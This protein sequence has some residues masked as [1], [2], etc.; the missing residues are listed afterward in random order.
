MTPQIQSLIA[1]ER[2]PENYSDM[3]TQ[4]WRPLAHQIAQW[5]KDVGR[6][7]VIG[8]N[9]AQG[10]GKST[11]CRFLEKALLPELGLTAVTMS[12]DDL[13]LTRAERDVLA[14]NV[15]PLLRTRGV[16]GTHEA[17]L[18]Q[19]VLDDLVA[20]RPTRF[21]QFSKALDDRLPPSDARHVKAKVDV[22]L[23]EGWCVGATSQTPSELAA[24]I[25]A[26]EAD[27]DPDGTWRRYVNDQLQ[28]Q[29]ADWFSRIDRLVMLKTPS[30]DSVLRNRLLQEHKLRSAS[31]DAPAAMADDQVRV[32]ISHYERLTKHMIGT[33]ADSSDI[34]F[35]LDDGQQIVRSRP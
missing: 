16:P 9:G 28:G 13:Y 11:L 34:C 3:V 18:G 20:G 24:P 31:P 25:N 27:C 2:L 5:R 35:D 17:A 23:F 6:P 8:V 10:S 7:L 12:L 1:S 15:H 33:M 29:Y 21:P 19:S 26:L 14:R 32:F 4:W 22:I 30:F